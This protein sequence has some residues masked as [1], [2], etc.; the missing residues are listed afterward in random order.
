MPA[1]CTF[2]GKFHKLGWI[3]TKKIKNVKNFRFALDPTQMTLIPRN[4]SII[5]NNIGSQ[6]RLSANDVR[7]LNRAYSCDGKIVTN[8]GGVQKV[9]DFLSY[10]DI[11]FTYSL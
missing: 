9:C 7:S 3:Q 8:G 6:S 11:C 4:S 1:Y 5:I 10:P 2:A